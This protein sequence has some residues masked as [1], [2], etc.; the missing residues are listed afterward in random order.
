MQAPPPPYSKLFPN[1][2]GVS[3]CVNSTALLVS[4]ASVACPVEATMGT[5]QA[6]NAEGGSSVYPPPPPYTGVSAPTLSSPTALNLLSSKDA[7]N[8]DVI[9]Q[10]LFLLQDEINSI[11]CRLNG[12]S[13]D[14]AV[15]DVQGPPPPPPAPATEESFVEEKKY[16]WRR[17][18]L[19]QQ[20]QISS[21]SEAL[22]RILSTLSVVPAATRSHDIKE[23]A[24]TIND[25]KNVRERE[26]KSC[27]NENMDCGAKKM[28]QDASV[29]SLMGTTVDLVHLLT[30]L[31]GLP[32]ISC[33]G[34]H[35]QLHPR[36][37]E[38]LIAAALGTTSHDLL[39]LYASLLVL[40]LNEGYAAAES[41]VGGHTSVGILVRNSGD[42][43]QK[44]LAPL[45][46]PVLESVLERTQFP[47]EIPAYQIALAACKVYHQ[48]HLSKLTS[49]SSLKSLSSLCVMS[50]SLP[51]I[52]SSHCKEEAEVFLHCVRFLWLPLHF[53]EEELRRCEGLGLVAE[54]RHCAI[55]AGLLMRL[56]QAIQAKRCL[57]ELTTTPARS[58]PAV[59]T[60]EPFLTEL[61]RVRPSYDFLTSSEK[62]QLI[63]GEKM[64]LVQ[65]W[66]I[67]KRCDATLYSPAV[68]HIWTA[69]SC[70]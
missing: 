16:A 59:F 53:L 26:T 15:S 25:N 8:S 9:L 1:A 51:C 66:R 67:Q 30:T 22:C 32:V 17:I 37:G 43:T 36:A 18:L 29:G 64:D 19:S 47:S 31:Y 54:A 57:N 55:Y 70:S 23:S 4:E 33:G 27:V 38:E 61:N 46:L 5:T 28:C 49:F 60:A 20:E 35:E 39:E 58:V 42:L 24:Q 41:N 48:R 50:S 62:K 13:F 34:C 11:K 56:R 14:A 52:S 68:C 21:L 44:A 2:G 12:Q 3:D 65:S 69:T 45:P 10:R 7:D 40:R 6:G 63:A